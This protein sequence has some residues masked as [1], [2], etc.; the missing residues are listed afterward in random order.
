MGAGHSRVDASVRWPGHTTSLDNGDATLSFYGAL[1]VADRVIADH[2]RAKEPYDILAR[3]FGTYVAL[4]A[5]MASSLQGL[6]RVILWGPPPYWYMWELFV[7]Q[8]ATSRGDA[9]NKGLRVDERFFATMEP[10]ELLLRHT[11]R[12]VIVA[13]GTEDAH[14]PPSFLRYLREMTTDPLAAR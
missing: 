14:S 4:K 11:V 1:A 9:L 5:T 8:L 2:E 7:G 3:S 13:T 12:T 6:R 10:L